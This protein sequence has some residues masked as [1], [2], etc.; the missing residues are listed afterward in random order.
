MEFA[1]ESDQL[2]GV[3]FCFPACV[4]VFRRVSFLPAGLEVVRVALRLAS[5]N[6][7]PVSSQAMPGAEWIAFL[8]ESMTLEPPP[9]PTAALPSDSNYK[10]LV[11][12]LS[13]LL[14]EARRTSA[15]AVNTV[16]TA[17]YWE[18]G[19]R[20]VEFEQ[21]G[22][23]R[24]GYGEAL[25]ERLAHDLTARFG[26]GF[27]LRNLR[28]FRTFYVEWPIRQTVSAESGGTI[29]QTPSAG[30]LTYA[31]RSFPLPWSH[32]VRLL[33]VKNADARA[34]YQAEAVRGG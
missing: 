12:E 28:N 7:R 11:T 29:R 31:A 32:Y 27:S 5:Q 8:P 2:R 16:M 3:R 9:M 25:L 30:S 4:V 19:R 20:L 1:A 21:G 24:A 26:R 33:A 22:A 18:F 17:T 6:V 10:G 34:F 13:R 15:R 23:R 14:E